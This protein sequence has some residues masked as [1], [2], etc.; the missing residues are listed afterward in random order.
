MTE[1]FKVYFSKVFEDIKLTAFE[2]LTKLDL[3]LKFDRCDLSLCQNCPIN[4]Y[5]LV[6]S[7]KVFWRMFIS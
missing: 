7:I 6:L 2:H 4:A 1:L 3:A 5:H